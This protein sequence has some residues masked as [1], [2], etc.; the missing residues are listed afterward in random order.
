LVDVEVVK[1]GTTDY[2]SFA[3]HEIPMETFIGKGDAIG[4]DQQ[5]GILKKWGIDGHEMELD[6]PLC[7]RVGSDPS[8]DPY[9]PCPVS[10]VRSITREP[11]H[12]PPAAW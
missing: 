6:R 4:G 10:L 8:A 7:R 9:T 2:Q 12:P 3:R 11:K 5:I 1:L